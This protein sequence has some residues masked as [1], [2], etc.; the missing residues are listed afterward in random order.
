[1]ERTLRLA[2]EKA[3][4]T[5]VSYNN[6]GFITPDEWEDILRPYTYEK[7]EIDYSCY[8]GG[9]NLQNRP[10]KVTEFLFIISSL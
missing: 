3:K 1:M 4:H 2:T 8:K 5:L 10:K 7:I 6:E 9:R